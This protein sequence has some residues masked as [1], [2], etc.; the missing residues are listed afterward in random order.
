MRVLKRVLNLSRKRKLK[1]LS[2]LIFSNENLSLL[3]TAQRCQLCW[4]YVLYL[5]VEHRQSFPS[6]PEILRLESREK[7]FCQTN[8]ESLIKVGAFYATAMLFNLGQFALR[9]VHPVVTWTIILLIWLKC[10]V[11]ER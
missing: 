8:F 2:N 1:R 4:L 9:N 5:V 11:L 10:H 3:N 7:L 6:S